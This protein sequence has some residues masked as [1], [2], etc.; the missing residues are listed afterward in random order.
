MSSEEDVEKLMSAVKER[1]GRLDVL[2]NNAGIMNF[3]PLYNP[4]EDKPHSLD[5]FKKLINVSHPL[6][7]MLYNIYIESVGLQEKALCKIQEI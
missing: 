5:D 4:V 2:I 3:R 6:Q 7:S 1:F